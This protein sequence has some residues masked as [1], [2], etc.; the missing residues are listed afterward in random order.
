MTEQF[1]IILTTT[2]K[3]KVAE[4]IATELLK[5]NLAA[6]VQ[7]DN[8]TSFFNWKD[9]INRNKEFRIMIKTTSSNYKK[10]ERLI[11]DNHN[12]ELPQII[13]IDISDGSQQY[14]QWLKTETT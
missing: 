10:I 8:I 12:Y 13:K 7:I 6:C 5:L 11:I 2:D 1:C 9:T 14:L 4:T 3:T